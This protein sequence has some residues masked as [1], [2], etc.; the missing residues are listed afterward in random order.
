MTRLT[1]LVFHLKSPIFTTHDIANLLPGKSADSLYGLVKRAIACGEIL[2]LRRGLYCLAPKFGKTIHPYSVAHVIYG[3]SYISL[4]TALSFHGWIPEAVYTITSV[5]SKKST[6]FDTRLGV[7]SYTRV[8]QHI[9]YEGV[10]F[11]SSSESYPMLMANPLKALCDY[12]YVHKQNWT[13]V[14]PLVKSLRMDWQNLEEIQANQINDLM[15]NYK[16]RRIQQFLS[17]L[18]KDL[19]L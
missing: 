18:R 17:G 14:S 4:E 11:S 19:G 10:N 2:H 3:P 6:G 8:P 7:F 9:L 12:I 15:E 5:S 1:E 16:S 13:T